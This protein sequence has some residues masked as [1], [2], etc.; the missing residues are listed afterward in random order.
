[1]SSGRQETKLDILCSHLLVFCKIYFIRNGEN[2]G[3][4]T[5]NLNARR[6]SQ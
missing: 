6:S 2:S 4:M 5:G 1:M 3:N